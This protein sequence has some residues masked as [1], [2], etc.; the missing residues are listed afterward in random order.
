MPRIIYS[1]LFEVIDPDAPDALTELVAQ[2]NRDGQSPTCMACP[3]KGRVI[4]LRIGDRVW[5]S[6]KTYEIKNVSAYRDAIREGL[7][8]RDDGYVVRD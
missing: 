2:L 3:P 6:G 5:H 7:P 8:A 4:D 1:L